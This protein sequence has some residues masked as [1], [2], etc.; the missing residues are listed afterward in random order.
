MKTKT[1]MSFPKVDTDMTEPQVYYTSQINIY[2]IETSSAMIVL[3]GC[4]H[5]PVILQQNMTERYEK[6]P[7]SFLVATQ[8]ALALALQY[9]CSFWFFLVKVFI[10]V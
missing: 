10:P 9:I 2:N 1:P 3:T 7:W 5:L 8:Q 6:R 4:I